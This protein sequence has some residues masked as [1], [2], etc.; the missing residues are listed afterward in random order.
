MQDKVAQPPNENIHS[1][2][3]TTQLVRAIS[4]TK[5]FGKMGKRHN[6]REHIQAETKTWFEQL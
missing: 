3:Y 6:V 5:L 2:T 1:V 4:L